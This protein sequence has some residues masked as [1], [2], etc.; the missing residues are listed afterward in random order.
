M[1]NRHGPRIVFLWAFDGNYRYKV[2]LLL[3]PGRVRHDGRQ[4]KKGLSQ[5][6]VA[7]MAERQSS[8]TRLRCI[9]EWYA[10]LDHR[11]CHS[12]LV[13]VGRVSASSKKCLAAP[14]VGVRVAGGVGNGQSPRAP[15]PG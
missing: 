1:G 4:K 10:P 3:A 12:S 14:G 8:R 9:Q 6:P 7:D 11:S 13:A 15:G 2:S 5:C